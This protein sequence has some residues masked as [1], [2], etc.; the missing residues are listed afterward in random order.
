MTAQHLAAPVAGP[1]ET[2]VL[3]TRPPLSRAAQL[4][5]AASLLLAGLLNGGTQFVGHLVVGDRDFS[6]QIRWGAEHP[7]FHGVEQ[8]VLLTSM[9]FLPIAVL[10]LA[11][12]TR[13]RAPR[14]TAVGIVLTVW[15]FW[16]FHNV[17][18]LGYTAGTIAPSALGVDS[19]VRLN[20]SFLEHPGAVFGALVPHLLGS[21]LGLIL[22]AIAGW[23]GRSLPRIPLV[24]LVAF[25]LWDF[26]LPPVGPLE[27][28]LLLLVSFGWLAVHVARMSWQEWSGTAQPGT[29]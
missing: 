29:Y 18:A 23:R 14:L 13:H 10:G 15:G 28:H 2:L 21:F 16:G 12:V 22:L 20:E 4:A 5:V 24:L 25:L 26:L 27:A 3:L 6:D 19:A 11:Q 9:L 8:F 17:L 7:V 1:N